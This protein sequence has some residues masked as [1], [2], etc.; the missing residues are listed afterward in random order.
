MSIGITY[1]TNWIVNTFGFG[2]TFGGALFLGVATSLPELTSTINLCKKKN[3]DAAYGNILGSCVFN[4][5]ILSF[6]DVL[7]F[8]CGPLYHIDQSS[9]LLIAGM[10]IIIILFLPTLLLTYKG[11]TKGTIG[12]RLFYA[13]VGVAIVGIYLAFL[14]LSNINLGIEFAP[15]GGN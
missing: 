2:E 15:F 8:N 9:F 5:L 1:H 7:S 6:S 3:F 13:F 12:F 14:I 10:I 11:K 4:F